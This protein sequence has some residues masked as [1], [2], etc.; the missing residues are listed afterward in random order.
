MDRLVELGIHAQKFLPKFL[1]T[2]FTKNTCSKLGKSRKLSDR[3]NYAKTYKLKWDQAKRCVNSPNLESCMKKFQN[4]DALFQRQ[5][6]PKFTKPES[7]APNVILSPAE[8]FVRKVHSNKS[9]HIKGANYTLEELIQSPTPTKAT[10]YIFRLAPEHYH[11]IH[12]PVNSKIR[13]IKAVGGDYSSVNPI[14]LESRPVLQENYRK[15]IELENGMYLAAIGATCIG[16]VYL[17]VKSGDNIKYGQDLG[18]FGFGGSC[19]VLVVPQTIKTAH[20]KITT[21]E[22][23]LMPGKLLASY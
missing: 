21:N 13:S 4:L 23:Y 18:T 15:I 20:V 2:N 19:V 11:R 8:C 7:T 16:S 17:N 6:L 9:F 10:I 3:I 5:I 12:S 22:S 1:A 14:M